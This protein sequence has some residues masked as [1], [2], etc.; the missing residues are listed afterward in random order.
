MI[1]GASR[2]AVR[3][4]RA[5]GKRGFAPAPS[6]PEPIAEEYVRKNADETAEAIKEL[7][8]W[9]KASFLTSIPIIGSI[10]WGFSG[11]HEHGHD[12]MAYAHHRAKQFPWGPCDLFDLKCK[13]ALK[14]AAE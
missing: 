14:E 7:S 3:V 8:T 6:V 12:T 5:T 4:V 2:Q 10:I 13:K 1:A 9:K 11:E